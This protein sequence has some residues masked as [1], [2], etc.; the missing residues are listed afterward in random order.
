MTEK[1]METEIRMSLTTLTRGIP[2]EIRSTKKRIE[3]LWNKETKVF[4]KCAP[5]ALEFLPKFDQIKK[6]ENKAAFASG[7]SLFFLVLGDE[8]FDTLKNF[9]LK[10]IQHPNGSV[11]E[12]IRKSADWL[13]ISL[14]ARAEPF[15]YPKTRSLTEKQKVVQAEAQ[16][17]YLNLAKE[18]ELLIELYDKGDTRVQYIDEMKPSVNKSLQLFW[19]RLTE[20]PVYRRILKQMRFQPYEIAKQRAEVEKEL[21]VILEK[22]KSDYTLQD[23][24]ECIFHEDGKEALTD[25]ISMFDTGQK[26]PSLDK[27]LETVNDAWNLFSHKILGGLSPAEKFLE[28]KKT[29]QKNKNMV[30]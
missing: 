16:K 20:S 13:F 7:L 3:A 8:Y 9:S 10:V 5:I 15:L 25:I 1:E 12:A 29:Q 24:Q 11:R 23:I 30:N 14:S 27:I 26:M 17:Q 18:I 2:E 4:K 21:V 19:S 28:Y 22:S 6:D